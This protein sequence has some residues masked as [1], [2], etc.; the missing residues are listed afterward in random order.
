[1]RLLLKQKDGQTKEYQFVEGPICIGRAADSHI[2]LPDSTVSKQHATIF[3]ADDGKWM[4]QDM[5]SANKTLLNGEPI[6]KVEIKSGDC[7]RIT[8]F[9]IEIHLENGV[10]IDE[11]VQLEDTLNLEAALATPPHEIVVR[12]PDAGHAPA[13]RLAAKRLT[14]FSQATETISGANNIEQL[15]LTL[16]DVTLKQFS[17]FHTWCAL[18]EQPSGPMTYHAGKRRDGGAVDLS[19]IKLSDKINQAVEKGQSLVL[20]RVAADI[21]E[22]ERIRSA[23]IAAVRRPVGCYGVLYVDNAMIHEHYSLSDLDYLM[24]LA[25]HTAASLRKLLKE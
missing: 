2:F 5:D 13:M 17:A 19:Q 14:D 11:T 16:L 25:M 23:M 6:H 7:L 20:P 10:A 1:M 18:R 9:T 8:D 15:L 24:L 4:V 3:I 22:K 21:E 12:K